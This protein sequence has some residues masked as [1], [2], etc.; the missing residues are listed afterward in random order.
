MMRGKKGKVEEKGKLLHWLPKLPTTP[1][2]SHAP[3]SH[4]LCLL[5]MPPHICPSFMELLKYS[6]ALWFSL[7]RFCHAVWVANTLM[8]V[9]GANSPLQTMTSFLCE[10]YMGLHSRDKLYNQNLFSTPIETKSILLLYRRQSAFKSDVFLNLSHLQ[11]IFCCD[12]SSS[13][14]TDA[15]EC[16]CLWVFNAYFP[17]TYYVKDILSTHLPSHA[18]NWP[19]NEHN[20]LTEGVFHLWKSLSVTALWSLIESQGFF[21]LKKAFFILFSVLT[22][23]V[24]TKHKKPT[25]QKKDLSPVF[26]LS[27]CQNKIIANLAYPGHRILPPP[28]RKWHC[29]WMSSLVTFPH[30]DSRWSCQ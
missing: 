16:L 19:L 7:Q 1:G 22:S 14:A 26:L 8:Y 12:G 15:L 18:G 24:A 17:L 2:I 6:R 13:D 23:T 20:R 5:Y 28:F 10:A 30:P 3:V 27:L 4:C 9:Y 25:K 21:S 29:F 11:K